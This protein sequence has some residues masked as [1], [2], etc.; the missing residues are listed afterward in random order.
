MSNGDAQFAEFFVAAWARVYRTTYAVAGWH[1]LTQDAVQDAFADAYLD[2]TR[3]SDSGN[4]ESEVA[5]TAIDAVLTVFRKAPEQ[6]SPSEFG[7]LTPN[8]TITVS[9]RC[10][11][12]STRVDRRDGGSR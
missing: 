7:P 6:D 5:T 2:W 12:M 11:R 1:G 8:G 10:E 9:A 4:P 3:V